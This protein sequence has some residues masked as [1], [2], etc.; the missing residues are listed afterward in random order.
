MTSP[1]P[2][3]VSA[4]LDALETWEIQSQRSER[5]ATIRAHIATLEARLAESE[6]QRI[7]L[8]NMLVLCGEREVRDVEGYPDKLRALIDGLIDQRR[9]AEAAEARLAEA[10]RDARRYLAL[11]NEKVV[12]LGAYTSRD[13]GETFDPLWGEKLDA[14]IDAAIAKDTP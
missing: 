2:P 13:N 9:R 14:A 7:P 4:A 12:P 5:A 3:E 1:T 10:G 11:R 6:D 8:T